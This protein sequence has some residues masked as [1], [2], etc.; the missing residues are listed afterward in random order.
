[1]S[2]SQINILMLMEQNYLTRNLIRIN[3]HHYIARC[4]IEGHP[5]VLI[6]SFLVGIC[7]TERFHGTVISRV[8]FCFRKQIPICS[9]TRCSLIN[10]L[11]ASGTWKY[12]P[13]TAKKRPYKLLKAQIMAY[14][15]CHNQL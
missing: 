8:Y 1:M 3:L 10:Y 11:L 14:I 2:Q 12:E 9:L 13:G 15:S 6:G 5:S 4:C 7:H